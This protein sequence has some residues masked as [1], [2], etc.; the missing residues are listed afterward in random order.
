MS[1]KQQTTPDLGG[2]SGSSFPLTPLQHVRTLYVA[3][4]QGLFS[5]A[6]PGYRWDPD[7]EQSEILITGENPVHVTTIGKRPAITFTRG[8]VQSYSMGID[9]MT[10]YDMQTGT[11]QKSVLIP[12]TMSVNCCSRVDLESEQIAWVC[13]EQLWLHRGILMSM[14]F[15]DIGRQFVVGSPSPPGSIISGDGGEEFYVT[16]VSSPF[17]FYRTSNYS[18]LNKQIVNHIETSLQMRGTAVKGVTATQ[19]TGNPENYQIEG[20]VCG[21]PLYKQ[22]HP[23]NPTQLVTVRS[24]SPNRPALRGPSIYGRTLPIRNPCVEESTAPPPIISKFN[25]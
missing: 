23:L 4:Y 10:Q 19:Q 5:S 1:Q 8:P 14:G 24:S 17:Q 21:L 3:F 22:P 2:L 12:G 7:N 9:D 6:Q 15:Y 18:P 16:T 20:A 25:V 11:K 13:A